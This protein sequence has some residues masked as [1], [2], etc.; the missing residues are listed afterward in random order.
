MVVAGS[1]SAPRRFPCVPA[2]PAP[3]LTH[4]SSRVR[5]PALS[6]SRAPGAPSAD[7]SDVLQPRSAGGRART[8]KRPAPELPSNMHNTNPKTRPDLAMD[9]PP[10]GYS[11]RQSLQQLLSSQ[12]CWQLEDL[13]LSITPIPAPQLRV[14]PSAHAPEHLVDEGESEP[15]VLPIL[16]SVLAFFSPQH[17]E[18]ESFFAL[19]GHRDNEAPQCQGFSALL[20]LPGYSEEFCRLQ[21]STKSGR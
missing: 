17:Q 4:R 14:L 15:R 20:A 3:V 11:G 2:H 12:R 10:H 19:L 7:V 9:A 13:W 5:G 8:G 21:D 16:V 18:Q 1:P 6:S